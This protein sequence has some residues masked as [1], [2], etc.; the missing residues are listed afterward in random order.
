[1]ELA[2]VGDLRL[3]RAEGPARAQRVL[4]REGLLAEAVAPRGEAAPEEDAVVGAVAR[5]RQAEPVPSP[6]AR[7]DPRRVLRPRGRLV[8]LVVPL[9]P[10][11]LDHLVLALEVVEARPPALRV[12][13]HVVP[14]AAHRPHLDAAAPALDHH[15][16]VARRAGRA[17]PRPSPPARSGGRSRASRPCRPP[18]AAPPPPRRRRPRA[19]ARAPARRRR[20]PARP[21]GRRGAGR[22]GRP[23]GAACPAASSGR[24]RAG[25]RRSRTTPAASAGRRARSPRR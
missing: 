11:A 6:V 4:A 8:G 20:C 5:P 19:A 16:V 1:M 3:A 23:P 13:E 21:P 15:A 9:R 7:R 24:P 12:V 2:V 18:R 22:S 14:D 25:G 17:A 10:R